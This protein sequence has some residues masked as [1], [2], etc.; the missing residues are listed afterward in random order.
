MKKTR[1]LPSL[2]FMVNP[3]NVACEGEKCHNRDTEESAAERRISWVSIKKCK[4]SVDFKPQTTR[5]I[6]HL[7]GFDKR[8][9][10]GRGRAGETQKLGEVWMKPTS[11]V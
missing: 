3:D 10:W 11:S 7:R 4:I 8:V 5:K 6:E 2:S 9:S 1:S